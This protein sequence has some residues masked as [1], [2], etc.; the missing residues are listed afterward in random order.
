M[1]GRGFVFLGLA[2]F[3]CRRKLLKAAKMSLA[4]RLVL[5]YRETLLF[6]KQSK[7]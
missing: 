1:H 6:G 2:C 7:K 5:F 3:V 4:T